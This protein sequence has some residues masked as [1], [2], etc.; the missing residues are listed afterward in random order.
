MGQ[1]IGICIVCGAVMFLAYLFLEVV[2]WS[3][4]LRMNNK[5]RRDKARRHAKG[6]GKWKH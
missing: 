2:V 3:E 6:R 1:V 4:L 5:E